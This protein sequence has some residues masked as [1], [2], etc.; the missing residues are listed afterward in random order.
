MTSCANFAGADERANAVP[1]DTKQWYVM[2][3]LKP[4]NA[5]NPAYKVMADLGLR[6][7][8]P[9]RWV[10]SESK[11]GKRERRQ[12]P[13]IQDLLFVYETRKVLDPI[14]ASTERLQYR[15][16]RGA[17]REALMT[18]PDSEMERFIGA[19]GRDST[20]V[21]YTAQELTADMIGKEIRVTGGPMDGYRGRL[22]KMRGSKRR[23][24]IVRI[25][26]FLAAAVEVDPDFI[27]VVP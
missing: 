10:L 7:F 19:V 14:V 21:Y 5:K 24:L 11:G 2:R 9:M 22:L 17:G 20:P 27:Q 18:V 16:R 25:E 15:Y 8:T 26:G 6:C 12:I 1:S 23:R 3:D 13:V 4:R